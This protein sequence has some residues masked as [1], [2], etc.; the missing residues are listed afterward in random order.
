MRRIEPIDKGIGSDIADLLG[1]LDVN[2]Q[3]Q[4]YNTFGDPFEG[5]GLKGMVAKF[6]DR[7]SSQNDLIILDEAVDGF[8]GVKNSSRSLPVAYHVIKANIRAEAR[9]RN[10]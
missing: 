10:K 5:L 1:H 2:S 6:T 4:S 8:Y 7:N 3:W 9:N